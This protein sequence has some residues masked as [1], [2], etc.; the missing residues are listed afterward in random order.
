MS[1]FDDVGVLALGTRL[2]ILSERMAKD[3]FA[4]YD[5]YGLDLHPKWF[6]VYRILSAADSKRVTDIAREIGHSHASVSK[7]IKEMLKAGI[8]QEG[9]DKKDG[10]TTIVCLSEKGKELLPLALTQ[11]KDVEGATK[12][13]LSQTQHNIWKAIEEWEYI[14]DQQSLFNRVKSQKKMRESEAIAIVP[15]EATHK[16]AFRDLN[17]EWIS[18]Y[19]TMEESDYKALDHPYEYIIDK[20]GYIFTAVM[21]E[22]PIGFCALI[23]MED[24]EFQFELA[25]MAVSP[26]AQGKGIGYKLGEA[27]I[28]KAKEVGAKKVYLES[29]TKLKPALSLYKKLGFEDIPNRHSPYER[30]NVQMGIEV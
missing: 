20:G 12:H 1:F 9:K 28:R 14:L 25:K 24:E 5:M 3:A 21:E 8:I 10:R 15:F 4:V 2:R 22:E 17:E 27:V 18:Q 7:I 11:F 26:K 29:N 6:P 16:Q 30:C 19:F 13:A 23:K